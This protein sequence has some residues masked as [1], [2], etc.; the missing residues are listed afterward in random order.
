MVL[1]LTTAFVTQSVL[2]MFG[3]T[4][5]ALVLVAFWQQDEGSSQEEQEE[6]EEDGEG[7]VVQPRY[8][9]RQRATVQRYSP[10][11]EQRPSRSGG[12]SGRHGRGRG[13]YEDDL[14]DLE[15]VGKD[16]NVH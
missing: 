9:R 4:P 1:H 10:K 15:Q 7:G 3:Q 12:I 13:H 6:D 16:F 11:R 14:S 2:G 8:S 5:G